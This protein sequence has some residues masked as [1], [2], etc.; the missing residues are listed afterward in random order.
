VEHRLVA[1][2]GRLAATFQAAVLV[3]VLPAFFASVVAGAAQPGVRIAAGCGVVV[4]A[5]AGW[6]LVRGAL[7]APP[8]VHVDPGGLTIVHPRVLREPVRIDRTNVHLVRVCHGAAGLPFTANVQ[9]FPVPDG[10][11][12]AGGYRWAFDFKNGSM[13]P[14]LT[15]AAAAPTVL[16]VLR[17]PVRLPVRRLLPRRLVRPGLRLPGRDAVAGLMLCVRRPDGMEPAVASWGEPGIEARRSLA[18]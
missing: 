18:S 1:R 7:G 15:A 9:R 17:D 16:I 14:T 2:G 6:W 4:S 12:A 8:A 5:V 13:F 11:G 10:P 3:G